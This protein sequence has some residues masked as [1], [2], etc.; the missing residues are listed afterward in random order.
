L[1]LDSLEQSWRKFGEPSRNAA[2]ESYKRT[3]R[4]LL[5]AFVGIAVLSLIGGFA[6]GGVFPIAR[7][8]WQSAVLVATLFWI[9]VFLIGRWALRRMDAIDR[10]RMSWRKGT[11]D[12]FAIANTLEALPD[13]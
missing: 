6:L 2:E 11:V 12:E 4:F 13:G 5:V 8:G 10:E 9:L 7:L 3:R 1:S